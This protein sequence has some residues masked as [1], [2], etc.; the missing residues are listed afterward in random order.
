MLRRAVDLPSLTVILGLH[1]AIAVVMFS[2][3]RNTEPAEKAFSLYAGNQGGA[4]NAPIQ[5]L[6]HTLR[7]RLRYAIAW[8]PGPVEHLDNPGPLR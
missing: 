2:R 4:E 5:D 7:L 8:Q 6:P 3:S 1:T